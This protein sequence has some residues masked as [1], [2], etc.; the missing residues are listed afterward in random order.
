MRLIVVG[1]GDLGGEVATRWVAE[2][3]KACG[4]TRTEDRHDS[5]RAA[6]VSPTTRDPRQL[7]LRSD[8]VLFAVSGSA[9]QAD[10][11][12]R[13]LGMHTR[14]AV[15]V[16]STG[17]Y[18]SQDGLLGAGHPPGR[19]SRARTAADAEA[20]FR[21]FAPDGVIVRLGGLYRAGRGPQSALARRG[22]APDGPDAQR[23]PLIHRDD[24]ATALLA[25]LRHPD[26]E[27]VYTGVVRP[28]PTRGDFYRLACEALGLPSPTFEGDGVERDWDTE[29]LHRDLL[30]EPR[31][32]DWE[33]GVRQAIADAR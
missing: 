16:S 2:G 3:G 12:R 19:S 28:A 26:P 15:F 31:W 29:A 21:R 13:L 20:A 32:P 1:A 8:A 4:V 10:V 5:L 27:P 23:L 6:G 17:V 30:P 24:A 25:A 22:H 11:V 14:R 7:I 33:A 9:N 18:G